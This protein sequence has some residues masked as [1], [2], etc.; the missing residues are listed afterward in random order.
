MEMIK[1]SNVKKKSVAVPHGAR[2]EVAKYRIIAFSAVLVVVVLAV[3]IL[4]NSSVS[5][6]LTFYNRVNPV[7]IPLFALATAGGAALWITRAKRGVDESGAVF[8][9]SM[10]TLLAGGLFA[11]CV[12]YIFLSPTR[13]LICLIA[14]AAL[15]Y[16]YYLYP[17]TFFVYAALT[18][19]GGLLLAFIR[20]GMTLAGLVVPVVLLAGLEL[21]IF[22]ML[23]CAKGR[24]AGMV[25]TDFRARLPFLAT[26]AVVLVGLVVGIVAPSML[27]YA[28]AI[29][30]ASFMVTAIV[31]TLRM[32]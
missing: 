31:Q 26:A 3:M 16:I 19:C 14:A 28:I 21:V 10:L 20:F 6:T 24:L 12:G 1:L 17:R 22:A 11:T 7:L 27:F 32:M 15:F 23:F 13:L 25:P 5:T 8:P 30:F 2:R 29:L 18:L 9:A 4:Q